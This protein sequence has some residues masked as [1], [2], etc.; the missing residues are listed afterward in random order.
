LSIGDRKTPSPK[1]LDGVAEV[2][3]IALA[4]SEP[5]TDK[6]R[7]SVRLLA[8]R[9]VELEGAEGIEE[10]ISGEL[11]RRTLKKAP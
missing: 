9:F 6:K 7:W 4:C 11:V 2:H 1:K 8:D 5:P 10:P 3:L